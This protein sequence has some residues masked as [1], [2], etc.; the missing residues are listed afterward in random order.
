MAN[1]IVDLDATVKAHPK[2]GQIRKLLTKAADA[3]CTEQEREALNAKAAELCAKYGISAA[4]A[5][6]GGLDG[7]EMILKEYTFYEVHH[8][9]EATLMYRIAEALGCSPILTRGDEEYDSTGLHVVGFE[10][11]IARCELM[12]ACLELQMAAGVVREFPRSGSVAARRGWMVAFAGAVGSRIAD[13]ERKAR[14]VETGEDVPPGTDLVLAN[15]THAVRAAFDAEYPNR[16]NR[17]SRGS[18][19]GFAAGAAAGMKANIGQDAVSNG[20]MALTA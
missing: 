5:A 16:T 14:D 13:A 8:S 7:E 3:S 6:A 15:R 2:L 12:Y 11:D 19:E 17:M 9:E 18:M 1:E 20:R 4:I 10:A